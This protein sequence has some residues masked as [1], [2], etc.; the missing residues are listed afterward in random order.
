[1]LYGSIDQNLNYTSYGVYWTSDLGQHW[2]KAADGSINFSS[3]LSFGD[4]T[5]GLNSGDGL[6]YFVPTTDGVS[7]SQIL[8]ENISVSP[9]PAEGQV[10]IAVENAQ[11]LTAE[12]YDVLGNLVWTDRGISEVRW[13][14]KGTSAVAASSG[15][16]IIKISGIDSQ[17][18]EFLE[19]RKLVIQ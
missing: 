18:G 16:Y 17:G 1:V 6:W 10:I 4:T 14:L 12:I 2:T 13:N 19:S 3:L 7:V 8:K 11:N 5:Y 15:I 9:N